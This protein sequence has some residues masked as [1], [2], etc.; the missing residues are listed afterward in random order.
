MRP[1]SADTSAPAWVKRKMLSTKNSTSW[2]SAS[3]KY[4]ATVRPDRPTR[5]RAPGGSFIWPYTSATVEPDD[6]RFDHLVIEVVA[7]AGALADAR[8]HRHAAV[9]LGDVVDQLHDRHGLA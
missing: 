9:R 8:E 5:A 6:A 4:S 7:L 1:S 3:R 2:P